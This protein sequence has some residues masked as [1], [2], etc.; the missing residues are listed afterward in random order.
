MILASRQPSIDITEYM[1]NESKGVEYN[2]VVRESS[3]TWLQNLER[4]Y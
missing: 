2:R 3:H 1:I 4:F